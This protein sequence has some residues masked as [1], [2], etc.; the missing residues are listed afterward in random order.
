MWWPLLI[1][2]S[3]VWFFFGARLMSRFGPDALGPAAGVMIAA[4]VGVSLW[5]WSARDA[6]HE[7]V[8]AG[9]CPRCQSSIVR[10]EEAPRPGALSDGLSGW[11][12]GSCGIEEAQPLTPERHA[13]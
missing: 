8:A 6:H 5:L 4:G 3:A 2:A 13:S 1:G 7:S 12:C 11:R 10:F 9:I